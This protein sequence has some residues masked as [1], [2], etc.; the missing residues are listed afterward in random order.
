MLALSSHIYKVADTVYQQM[1]RGSDVDSVARL[2]S[3]RALKLTLL[4]SFR[5]QKSIEPNRRVLGP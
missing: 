3:F 1:A 4:E 5:A 2:E